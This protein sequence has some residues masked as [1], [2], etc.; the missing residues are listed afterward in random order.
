MQQ[1]SGQESSEINFEDAQLLATFGEVDID[2]ESLKLLCF[3]CIS[4]KSGDD[5]NAEH[6]RIDF[7]LF[8]TA[9]QNFCKLRNMGVCLA[10]IRGWLI[11]SDNDD[12]S[13][14]S[15]VSKASSVHSLSLSQ[16]ISQIP[17]AKAQDEIS[18]LS[19]GSGVH[20][21]LQNYSTNEPLRT[22]SQP[23]GGGTVSGSSDAWGGES[24]SLIS[25][26]FLP[27]V[28]RLKRKQSLNAS[29]KKLLAKAG[30]DESL[31]R[32]TPR[33]LK[34]NINDKVDVR[35]LRWELEMAQE[36]I[37]QLDRL[38]DSNIAWV[39]SNCDMSSAMA[40]FSSRTIR[41][42]KHMA[43]ERIFNVL[44]EYQGVTVLWAFQIWNKY[45]KYLQVVDY[46]K[47]YCKI[48]SIEILSRIMHSS[49]FRQYAR[50]WRPWKRHVQRAI[51]MERTAATVEIQKICRGFLGRIYKKRKFQS[52][53]VVYIQ[54]MYRK[55]KARRIVDNRYQQRIEKFRSMAATD[56]QNFLRGKVSIWRAKEEAQRRRRVKAAIKIQKIGRGNLGRR[57]FAQKV[58]ESRTNS[59]NS[60]QRQFSDLESIATLSLSSQSNSGSV[61]STTRSVRSR[62]QQVSKSSSVRTANSSN[63]VSPKKKGGTIDSSKSSTS[64]TTAKGKKSE[65]KTK[66]AVTTDQKSQQ[67]KQNSSTVSMT[68]DSLHSKED[69][70]QYVGSETEITTTGK[71]ASQN[72][73]SLPIPRT[74]KTTPLNS[75][76]RSEHSSSLGSG[77]VHGNT[78]QN[79]SR[80]S[81]HSS[82]AG[83]N[84]VHGT[85]TSLDSARKSSPQSSRKPSPG[86]SR[87]PK[88]SHGKA[89]HGTHGSHVANS[90]AQQSNISQSS[91][92][93]PSTVEKHSHT[94]AVHANVSHASNSSGHVPVPHASHSKLSTAEKH[95]GGTPITGSKPKQHS[96]P[97]STPV[98]AH[99]TNTQH[100]SLQG[101]EKQVPENSKKKKSI[102]KDPIA[103]STRN[104]E[105]KLKIPQV[106][107]EIV[108]NTV[109][110]AQEA[111]EKRR[112]E[113]VEELMSKK[114]LEAQQEKIKE[115]ARKGPD[116]LPEKTSEIVPDQIE[117]HILIQRSRDS[118]PV[119]K[120]APAEERDISESDPSPSERLSSRIWS[121]L[122]SGKSSRS[123]SPLR[124][125]S[126]EK[127]MS[128]ISR[129]GSWF[130][131]PG[132]ASVKTRKHKGDSSPLSERS[133]SS[134][135]LISIPPL[136]GVAERDEHYFG[137]EK[138]SGPRS[139]DSHKRDHTFDR[140]QTPSRPSSHGLGPTAT[141]ST[142]NGDATRLVSANNVGSVSVEDTHKGYD[143]KP[144]DDENSQA[145][146]KPEPIVVDPK[147]AAARRIQQLIRKKLSRR[148]VQSRRQQMISAQAIAGRVIFWA[149]ITI[150][151]IGRGKLGRRRFN[152]FS[153]SKQVR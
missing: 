22:R 25:N 152:T 114:L 19:Y 140:S 75:S 153:K 143:P 130:A 45:S 105:E 122:G 63:G 51:F 113:E 78:P 43:A 38:V 134:S 82:M 144:Q 68:G 100:G 58:L 36:G 97:D 148:R 30:F 81:E 71:S 33:V 95:A 129:I 99:S 56:I 11:R 34:S 15:G 35:T 115:E 41:K 40:H 104:A 57:K 42:C 31:I 2:I 67:P 32:K 10:E 139:A 59:A 83:H 26:S 18:V 123:P 118:S 16:S 37:K 53:K 77:R 127:I 5:T 84:K 12:A 3:H 80:R 109:I 73:G 13:Q 27:P 87:E 89:G 137:S 69:S 119:K 145:I 23:E 48:K 98:A 133:L 44:V 7:N 132:S 149:A 103:K 54:C 4:A 79:S 55:W 70:D 96:D 76:R 8:M 135:P 50:G 106:N 108:S 61:P 66:S 136:E 72:V 147:Y 131:L 46:S 64:A 65:Y 60:K 117:S 52:K 93:K 20:S 138:S 1:L 146:M 141:G 142:E 28:L 124:P 111:E 112:K 151:R 101:K 102:V 85:T 47:K 128:G 125:F 126:S 94:N 91:H 120:I 90:A 121:A 107:V 92:V 150:Q 24:I 21:S 86:L 74:D 88:N 29:K 6:L 49:L 62:T 17:S 14:H 39:Q 116:L 9:L 110:E